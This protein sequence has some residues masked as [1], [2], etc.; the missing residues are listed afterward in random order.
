VG[1]VVDGTEWSLRYWRF[2]GG[3]AGYVS[4]MGEVSIKLVGA[5]TEPTGYGWRRYAIRAVYDFDPTG[6]LSLS[7]LEEARRRRPEATLPLPWSAS[8]H[9]D[10]AALLDQAGL[11]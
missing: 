4:G 3:W 9:P 5:G 11:L 2:A 7:Q 6:R 1:C 8:F 10:Q